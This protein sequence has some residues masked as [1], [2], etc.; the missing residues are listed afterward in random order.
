MNIPVFELARASP[1]VMQVL[2]KGGVLRF[3]RFGEAPQGVESPYA[4]WQLV[5]GSPLNRLSG[6]PDEDSYGVQV[7]VYSEKQEV[8]DIAVRLRDAFEL[9]GYI[10]G[11]NGETREAETRLYRFSFRVEFMTSRPVSS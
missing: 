8:A 3:Y 9:S 2:S 6:V 5:Y 4:V 11:W 10:V 1:Q 7:D